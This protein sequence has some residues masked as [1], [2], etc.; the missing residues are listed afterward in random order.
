METKALKMRRIDILIVKLY[1]DLRTIIENPHKTIREMIE[2]LN[3]DHST[4]VRHLSLIG[5][6]K[7]LRRCRI[8]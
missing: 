1:K 5:K 8:S 4:V 6:T 2:E 7:E 3:V